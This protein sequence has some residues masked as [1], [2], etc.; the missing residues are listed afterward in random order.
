MTNLTVRSPG[1][2]A[3]A[4]QRMVAATGLMVGTAA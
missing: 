4:I 2:A 3:Q 1:P